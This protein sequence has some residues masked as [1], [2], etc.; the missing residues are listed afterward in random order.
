M[1]ESKHTPGPWKDHGAYL[2][3]DDDAWEGEK[4]TEITSSNQGHGV[5]GPICQVYLDDVDEDGWAEQRANARL[6]ARAPALLAENERLRGILDALSVGLP[7]LDSVRALAF[8]AGAIKA[9]K[10]QRPGHSDYLKK[11]QMADL[12]GRLQ[13]ATE[14]L[15]IWLRDTR[16]ALAERSDRIDV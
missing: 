11:D 2:D 5:G 6:I 9:A 10:G 13:K 3:K 12:A 8:A 1:T 7:D 4:W 15:W 14:T 16:A